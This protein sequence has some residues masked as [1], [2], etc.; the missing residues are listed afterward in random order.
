[1]VWTS[2]DLYNLGVLMSSVEADLRAIW[3]VLV[4]L[5]LVSAASLLLRFLGR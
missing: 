5:L 4:V 1:M 2:G 3:S